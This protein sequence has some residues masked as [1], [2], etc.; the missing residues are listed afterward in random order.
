MVEKGQRPELNQVSSTSGSCS[1]LSDPQR[2]Q[3][4]GASRATMISW[5][6]PQCQAGM[7]WPHH[8]CRETHQSRM[9]YI[10]SK[11]VLVQ[12][13]GMNSI[14]FDST[15]AMAFSASGFILM[16]HCFETSGS[17]TVLQRWHLPTLKV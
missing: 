14:R 7:R 9:L 17:M 16:N 10:H 5:Q 12:F 2:A 15:A 3:P 6:L 11:Y 1:N 4:D 8:N 13:S